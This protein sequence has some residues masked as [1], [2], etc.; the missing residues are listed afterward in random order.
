MRTTYFLLLSFAAIW[1]L[2]VSAQKE[3]DGDKLIGIW[4]LEKHIFTEKE[5][6]KQCTFHIHFPIL[7]LSKDSTYS[8]KLKGKLI[9]MG[10]WTFKKNN[11]IWFYN[12][13]DMPDDPSVIIKDRGSLVLSVKSSE[14]KLM[15]HQ[16]NPKI[17]GE[18]VYNRVQ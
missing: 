1:F 14:L 18:S 16:C 13:K 9:E 5:E 2:S 15:E 12:C 7:Q 6:K 10:K 8:I 4:K 17:S 11:I 3:I